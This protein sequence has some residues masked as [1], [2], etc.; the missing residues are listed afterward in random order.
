M[1]LERNKG[2]RIIHAEK[3][4]YI[5]IDM[6]GVGFAESV[7]YATE[8]DLAEAVMKNEV[9][10]ESFFPMPEEQASR[11]CEKEVKNEKDHRMLDK[12]WT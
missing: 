4:W 8:K 10:W 9:A 12:K 5:C 2:M 1:D 3:G 7:W 6:A 11:S